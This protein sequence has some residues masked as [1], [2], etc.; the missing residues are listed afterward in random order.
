M[1]ALQ[2]QHLAEIT[3]AKNQIQLLTQNNNQLADSINGYKE[4]E[5]NITTELENVKNL[6]GAS[7][8][9]KLE[10]LCSLSQ[11]A[12]TLRKQVAD[13]EIVYARLEHAEQLVKTLQNE[14]YKNDLLRRKLHNDIQDLKGNIRV[15][16]RV[17]PISKSD[18]SQYTDSPVDCAA[19]G[20]ELTLVDTRGKKNKFIFDKVFDCSKNQIDIFEEVS[21]LVQSALDGYNVCLFTYGQT[22]SGKTFTIQGKGIG[23]NRGIIPRSIEKVMEQCRMLEN[24][25]WKYTTEV[26]FLEIYN[27]NIRDLL[28]EGTD[29]NQN[30]Q[31]KMDNDNHTYIPGLT[32][33]KVDTTNEIKKLMAIAD[34]HRAVGVYIIIIFF[35]IYRQLQ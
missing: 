15:I 17:R 20:T 30:L 14:C 5:Y 2:K 19:D 33:V 22:G 25:G 21:Q 3:E 31:I 16:A 12:E 27:E 35:I 6:A 1:T 10:K 9:S 24:Q 11:E 18:N 4:R 8:K 28:S 23:D 29:E 32:R 7:E 34:K 26:T 13:K